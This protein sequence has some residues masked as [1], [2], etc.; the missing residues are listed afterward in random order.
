MI[1]ICGAF[2]AAD[3]THMHY[4]ALWRRGLKQKKNES[5]EMENTMHTTQIIWPSTDWYVRWFLIT[6]SYDDDMFY[7]AEGEKA[8]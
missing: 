6:D 8:D 5:N 3:V 4:P 2:S 7:C 1:F